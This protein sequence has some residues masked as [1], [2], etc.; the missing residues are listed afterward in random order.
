MLMMCVICVVQD[1]RRIAGIGVRCD[2]LIS[3]LYITVARSHGGMCC[4]LGLRQSFFLHIYICS[5]SVTSASVC[6]IRQVRMPWRCLTIAGAA[7]LHGVLMSINLYFHIFMRTWASFCSLFR[8][9]SVRSVWVRVSLRV[10]MKECK[11][12][13]QEEIQQQIFAR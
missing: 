4:M 10:T 1:G 6:T 11:S 8:S 13:R 2:P 7:N 5:P 3:G 12:Y 9:R